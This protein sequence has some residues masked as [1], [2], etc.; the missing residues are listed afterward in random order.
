MHRILRHGSR[1]PGLPEEYSQ[2]FPHPGMM[3]R[4][5]SEQ[6]SC[7]VWWSQILT[8][9]AYSIQWPNLTSCHTL[10]TFDRTLVMP[11]N[12]VCP[13]HI[14]LDRFILLHSKHIFFLPE[15][16]ES[17]AASTHRVSSFRHWTLRCSR[18]SSRSARANF[19]IYA[20]LECEGDR[21]N[22][23]AVMLR[24]N[25]SF[26]G[27]CLLHIHCRCTALRNMLRHL[28]TFWLRGMFGPIH[29]QDPIV[30]FVV[31]AP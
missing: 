18:G 14:T 29:L 10:L 13:L 15:C 11:L 2:V 1:I 22:A 9:H 19:W 28:T 30:A 8:L 6:L 23:I 26:G 16:F 4:H 27:R 7:R 21:W 20:W 24:V 25:L 5:T 3:F 31:C 12:C 17:V